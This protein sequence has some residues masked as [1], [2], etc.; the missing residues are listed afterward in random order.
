MFRIFHRETIGEKI[1]KQAREQFP[2]FL[3]AT[4]FGL[5]GVAITE[6]SRNIV[7]KLSAPEKKAQSQTQQD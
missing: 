4:G 7:R 5:A 3:V 1:V 2:S 6:G